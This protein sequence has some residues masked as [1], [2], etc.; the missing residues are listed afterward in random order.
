MLLVLTLLLADAWTG[1]GG[2]CDFLA[3]GAVSGFGLVEFD[4]GAVAVTFDG[5]GVGVGAIAGVG[6]A[7]A[8]TPAPSMCE[9]EALPDFCLNFS[10]PAYF[11]PL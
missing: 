6:A 8:D 9:I 4:A 11:P 7:A 2:G 1:A 10:S 3:V 5:A